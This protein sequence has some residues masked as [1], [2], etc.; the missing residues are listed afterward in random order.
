MRVDGGRQGSGALFLWR[1]Y[2]LRKCSGFQQDLQ[3]TGS[4]K[5][6]LGSTVLVWG[7]QQNRK[8]QREL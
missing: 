3:G 6:G 5:V 8:G 4:R 1:V 7:H 2:F